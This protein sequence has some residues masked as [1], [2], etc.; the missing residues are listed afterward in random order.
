MPS[1]VPI[2]V[3]VVGSPD[4]TISDA[5]ALGRAFASYVNDLRVRHPHTD[6][7]VLTTL[8]SGP[9]LAAMHALDREEITVIACV[10]SGAAPPEP[11][12]P[13]ADTRPVD[14]DPRELIAYASDILV[15][16]SS[17]DAS[18]ELLTFADRRRTGEPPPAGFRKVLAP[19]DVGAYVVLEGPSLQQF[20][21]PRFTG[22][23]S[24]EAE[25]TASMR[26]RDRYNR[27]IRDVPAPAEGTHI[28]RLGERTDSVAN[29]LQSHTYL[30][31]HVLYIFGFFAGIVQLFG[32]GFH[33]RLFDRYP[34]DDLK[35]VLFAAAFF[36]FAFMRWKDYQSRYQDYRA[37]S[38]ALRVQAVWS[39]VGIEESVEESYLP[40]QQTDLQWI[41]NALR[42]IHFLDW[43]NLGTA[44]DF[45]VVT[46]WAKSQHGYFA[47]ASKREARMRRRIA[48]AAS[49][50]GGCTIIASFAGLVLKTPAAAADIGSFA[51]LF[52]LC[53]AVLM[54][55]TRTRAHAE[56][57]NRYQRMFFVFGTAETLLERAKG[58][59]DRV[60]LVARE[61][62]REALGE[63]ADWLLSQRERPIALV[64]TSVT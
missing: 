42:T 8:G 7:V 25:F 59:D 17:A 31:Q 37:I 19:P 32:P 29:V 21:P 18:P 33:V 64:E 2:L 48:V 62:G 27:D 6:V 23:V 49:V 30:G 56:N 41:R 45:D 12:F 4:D 38:E 63:H 44:C 5:D 58:H 54:S 39:A 43:R 57:A 35:L 26:H 10:R 9:E 46:G 36:V 28:E 34:V 16:V 15:I 24:A 60:R 3:G 11:A 40:M 51:A 1:A 20:F 14:G 61:L 55:Y 52:T 50:L 22:D 47:R 13:V 53:V